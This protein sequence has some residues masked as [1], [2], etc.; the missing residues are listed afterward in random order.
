M[1]KQ[2]CDASLIPK[3]LAHAK[4]PAAR[5]TTGSTVH[6][7]QYPLT[8]TGRQLARPAATDNEKCG[9]P[10]IC[11]RHLASNYLPASNSPHS[12]TP[13]VNLTIATNRQQLSAHSLGQSGH[14]CEWAPRA[15]LRQV[16]EGRRATGGQQGSGGQRGSE[17]Q[18]FSGGQRGSDGRPATSSHILQR[19]R[20][21][22]GHFSR[23][24]QMRRNL[25][26]QRTLGL[27]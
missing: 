6:S 14:G 10:I 11:K 26:L 5:E 8:E 18:R 12:A 15:L 9:Q 21:S 13:P 1:R 20:R 24:R 17:G 4:Q 3:G 19:L 16:A 23:H 2:H 22:Q 27:L 25:E 7:Q